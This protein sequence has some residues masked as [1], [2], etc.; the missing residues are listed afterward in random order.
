[1]T[2]VY[3]RNYQRG[4]DDKASGQR[5]MHPAS[6]PDPHAYRGYMDGWSGRDFNQPEAMKPLSERGT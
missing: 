6:V 4:M 2:T 3:A 1:M 5:C